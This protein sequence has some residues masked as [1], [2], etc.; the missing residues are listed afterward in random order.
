MA[1]MSYTKDVS[2]LK[3]AI[4]FIYA[5]HPELIGLS[6]VSQT[7]NEWFLFCLEV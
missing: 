4:E 7:K 3:M 2:V 5:Q 6:E 1:F